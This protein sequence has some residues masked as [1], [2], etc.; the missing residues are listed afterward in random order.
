MLTKK[1]KESKVGED[2]K[3]IVGRIL[4]PRITEQLLPVISYILE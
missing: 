1:K 4:V 2:R 3:Y